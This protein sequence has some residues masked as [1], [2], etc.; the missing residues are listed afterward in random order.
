MGS[1][2]VTAA[3]A[4]IRERAAHADRALKFGGSFRVTA[5]SQADVPRL[6]AA[7][8]AVLKEHQPVNRGEGLE[9]ICSTCHR[10][11][12]PCPTVQAITA[13]LSGEEAGGEEHATALP[14]APD[15]DMFPLDIALGHEGE[16]PWCVLAEDGGRADCDSRREAYATAEQIT[17]TGR[18]AAVYIRSASRYCFARYEVITEDGKHG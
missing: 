1:D 3:L 14:M 11:F 10:G 16:P 15:T 4:A 7:V 8:E 5:R 17:G 2:D 13:A 12:W 18:R 9:P 6:V